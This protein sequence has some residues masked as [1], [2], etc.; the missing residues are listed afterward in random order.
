PMTDEEL[1]QLVRDKVPEEL[2][3]EQLAAIR[4][5]LPHN[6][7]LREMLR[8]QLAADENLIRELGRVQISAT[9]LWQSAMVVGPRR[10]RRAVA[11]ASVAVLGLAVAGAAY[12][13]L[14][15]ADR[16]ARTP[17][18]PEPRAVASARES[19]DPERNASSVQPAVTNAAA[20]RSGTE[21][22]S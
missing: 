15:R 21:Q 3:A 6:P 8:R 16:G 13:W 17:E 5:R 7:G 20:A 12:R 10:R 4:E 19:E 9:E 2:S 11:L 1:L 18:E 22:A 14:G